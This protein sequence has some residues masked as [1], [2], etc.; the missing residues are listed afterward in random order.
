M[1]RDEPHQIVSPGLDSAD[2]RQPPDRRVRPESKHCVTPSEIVAD[3]G[4]KR[5]PRKHPPCQIHLTSS[6]GGVEP[7]PC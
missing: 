2:E 6:A 1:G 4:P 5:R 3:D 7:T